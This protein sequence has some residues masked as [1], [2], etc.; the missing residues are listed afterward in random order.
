MKKTLLTVPFFTLLS[1]SLFAQDH[2]EESDK[3]HRIT[4]V[5]ANTHVNQIVNDENQIFIIPTWGLDYHYQLSKRF[6][7]GLQ[8]DIELMTFEVEHEGVELQRSY[9]FSTSLVVSAKVWKELAFFVG[10]GYELEKT[11]NFFQYV[12][13]T[14]YGFRMNENWEL[15]INLTYNNKEAYYDSWMFGFGLSRLF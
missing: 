5:M 2:E 15:G 6:A 10:P 11:R 14:E 8:N 13:G 9:P 7:L 4:L 12:I 3:K 1:L